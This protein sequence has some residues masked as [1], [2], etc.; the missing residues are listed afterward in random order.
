VFL[1]LLYK[2]KNAVDY[3]IHING[4]KLSFLISQSA[5]EFK[6]ILVENLF[7]IFR[8]KSI[9]NLDLGL[10][11]FDAKNIFSTLRS[12]QL[13]VIKYNYMK[14]Y[15]INDNNVFIFFIQLNHNKIVISSNSK[16]HN[17]STSLRK[18]L[19]FKISKLKFIVFKHEHFKA[20]M[21]EINLNKNILVICVF[22]NNVLSDFSKYEKFT[23]TNNQV[24]FVFFKI[25][26][27]I[28]NI[29]NFIFF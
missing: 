11:L 18:K 3:T 23:V 24:N 13:L 27:K 17:V 6:N 19:P 29:N 20:V 16:I 21:N 12:C 5:D 2:E 22:Y 8:F 10:G 25:F 15:F 28:V 4:P 1:F 7:D 26:E 14:K 9:Y